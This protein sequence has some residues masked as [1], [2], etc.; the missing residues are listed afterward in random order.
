MSQ[1]HYSRR[2][3]EPVHVREM[4][5]PNSPR[6]AYTG[7]VVKRCEFTHEDPRVMPFSDGDIAAINRVEE[8]RWFGGNR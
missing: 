1:H 4:G 8:D 3:E 2:E 5:L 7:L 6:E